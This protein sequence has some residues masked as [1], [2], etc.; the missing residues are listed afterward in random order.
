MDTPIELFPGRTSEPPPAAQPRKHPFGCLLGGAIGCLASVVVLFGF[1][2]LLIT[3]LF[4]IGG[5]L[6][7]Q[8]SSLDTLVSHSQYLFTT[9]NDESKTQLLRLEL[10]GV[11]TGS[12]PSRWYAPPD[13][14]ASVLEE[15]ETIREDETC[16][17]LLL[18]IDSP[19]G[20]VTASDTLY[21]ALERFK[22]FD[23]ERKVIVLGR[24]LLASGAYYLSMQADWIRLQPTGLVGSIGVIMPGVNLHGLANK[25][26]IADNSI[27]S[28]TAKDLANPLKPV[29]PEHNALLS[30]MVNGL[31]QRFVSLVAQG[32]H[33]AEE[34]VRRLADGRIYLA[35][36][37]RNL[38][39][40]D[41]IGYED[42]L[43]AKLAELYNCDESDI[44]IYRP[45]EKNQT[46]RALLSEFPS[47]IGQAIARPL[48]ETQET[49][50]EMRYR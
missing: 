39:L 37:A 41:D 32:R 9:G 18:V 6:I 23:P 12:A 14:D 31:Q 11:I 10:N 24:D 22:A 20:S 35:E 26:G 43:P 50:L 47:A 46:W 8:S 44:G 48:L 2:S 4:I 33:L 25:L 3:Y 40:I 49:R 28:G 21:H 42:T 1:F 13:C 34:D 16:K 27:A 5:R 45:C 7:R 17:G 36:D 15:I 29:N 19:G 38:R 30:S